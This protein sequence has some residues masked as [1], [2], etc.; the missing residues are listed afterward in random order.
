[1]KK[2]ILLASLVICFS[3]TSKK[4]N[5]GPKTIIRFEAKYISALTDT[6]FNYSCDEILNSYS[7]DT[8]IINRPIFFKDIEAQ[9]KSLLPQNPDSTD[10]IDARICCKL[11]FSNNDTS[12]LTFGGFSGTVFD[13]RKMKDNVELSYLIK[14]NIG[15]FQYFF[16][17]DLQTLDELKDTLKLREVQSKM[18]KKVYRSHILEKRIVSDSSDTAIIQIFPW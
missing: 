10:N 1:M 13:G 14:M 4:E 18:K 7:H 5:Q 8:V 9:I 2:I 17:D 15:F 16:F 3:C 6:P 11:I 12:Y